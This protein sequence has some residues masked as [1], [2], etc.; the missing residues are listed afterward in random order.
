MSVSYRRT[1]WRMIGGARSYGGAWW[2]HACLC[3]CGLLVSDG[4]RWLG[5]GGRG[6]LTVSRTSLPLPD[7]VLA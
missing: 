5:I 3:I 2:L 6:H 7:A 4:R 1:V